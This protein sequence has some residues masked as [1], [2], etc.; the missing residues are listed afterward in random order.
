M[1][2]PKIFRCIAFHYKEDRLPNLQKIIEASY[3]DDYELHTVITTN[4]INESDL[5]RVVNEVRINGNAHSKIEITS[6][7][8]LPN[9]WLLTWTHKQL[10]LIAFR[11]RRFSHYI[12]TE[13]DIRL[14]EDNILNWIALKTTLD[15]TD[16]NGCFPSFARVE[17]CKKSNGWKYTDQLRP[18]SARETPHIEARFHSQRVKLYQLPNPYQ[19]MYIYD[20][21]LM[22]E[23][24]SAPTF[25][26]DNCKS[27]KN[28]DNKSWGGGGVAEDSAL[29]LTY[30][31]P[32]Y[33]F[34]TRNLLPV[35]SYT[36]IPLPGF[37]IHHLTNNYA[38]NHTSQGF[39]TIGID[40]LIFF[41]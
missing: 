30:I 13:D 24:V 1:V 25:Q 40:N 29:G 36:C 37:L 33:P 35:D 3:S 18:I 32:K 4:A 6:F 16:K 39:A 17:Y 27:L 10:M 21:E 28:I 7:P 19:A 8:N 9:P 5:E 14:S 31:K 12:Y 38:E 20:D 22:G 41:D 2:K 26:I 11:S 23:Y 15:L 34:L